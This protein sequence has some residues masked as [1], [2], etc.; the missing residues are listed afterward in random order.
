NS[1]VV[2]AI[3][4]R[5]SN[6]SG[7]SGPFLWFWCR[8]VTASPMPSPATIAAS[9]QYRSVSRQTRFT[10]SSSHDR[11]PCAKPVAAAY[12]GSGLELS[13]VHRDALAHAD[14]AVSTLVA[15]APAWSVVAHGEFH[16]PVAVADEDLRVVR[17]GVLDG[18]RQAFL[19][20]PVRGEIDT[21]R[22]LLRC[23]FDPQLDR[24]PRLARLL[25]ELVEVLEARLGGE[26]GGLFGPAEDAD[27]APHLRERLAAGLFDDEQCLTLLLLMRAEQSPPRRGLHGHHADA[28][29]DD[30]VQLAC[31]SRALVRHCQAS[32]FLP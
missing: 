27:H 8:T 15:V 17:P 21:G 7:P 26:R 29:A 2:K 9:N 1:G 28:V 32:L 30:V 13:A 20:E 22:K 31:D 18:V 11:E 16:V 14:E 25:D 6:Q 10:L 24:K 19:D 5:M 3:T 23:A 12:A 4:A